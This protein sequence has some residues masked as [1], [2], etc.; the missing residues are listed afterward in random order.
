M[1]PH[2]VLLDFSKS[3]VKNVYEQPINDS[4]FESRALLK[5]FAI[6]SA[7]ARKIYGENARQLEQPVVL[8][9]IQLDKK[10]V[11]FG[12]FQLNTFDL[13]GEGGV[14]NYWFRKPIS[15]LYDECTYHEGRPQLV[16]YNF[17]I[18]KTM[19]VLYGS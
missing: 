6:T 19:C 11:Q 12:I 18:F 4:Q 7:W 9:T 14:K 1:Y 2:T 16:N 8:Q 10:R 5:A 15:D 13:Q 17:N 3:Y